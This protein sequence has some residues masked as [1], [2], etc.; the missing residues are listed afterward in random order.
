[1]ADD[2]IEPLKAYKDFLKDKVKDNA[3]QYF[4]ELTQKSGIDVE[5]NSQTVK[6]YREKL[7][8]NESV[9][10]KVRKISNLW[11]FFIIFSGVITLLGAMSLG[12]TLYME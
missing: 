7:K 4:D 3:I 9:K 5:A 12:Y 6:K 1:M 2:L 10:Q 11:T 8:D